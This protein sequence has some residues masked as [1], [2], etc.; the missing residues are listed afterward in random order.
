M[1]CNRNQ[2]ADII[3][4]DV[5]T[6]DS[7]VAKG[8]PYLTRPGQTPGVKNW[9]F[10][11]VDVLQWMLYGGRAE[12]LKQAEQRIRV[13]TAGIKEYEYARLV[14]AVMPIRDVIVRVEEVL[15]A[16]K[17]RVVALPGRVAQLVAIESDPAKVHA[18]LKDEI[19]DVLKPLDL[20][21]DPRG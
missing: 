20:P 16:V 10:E 5:K 1:H 7:M 11:T 13:A 3:G 12:Q 17:S 14:G 6:I 4:R 8:M 15:M 9:K 21:F 19:N 2:L 18:I